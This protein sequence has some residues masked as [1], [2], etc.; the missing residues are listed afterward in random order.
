MAPGTFCSCQGNVRLQGESL[1]QRNGQ[2]CFTK[3]SQES[4]CARP[5][6][7]LFRIVQLRS[8]QLLE[9][10]KPNHLFPL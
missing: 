9:A 4:K 10:I 2:N 7:L 1:F 5:F 6:L 8:E 3:L